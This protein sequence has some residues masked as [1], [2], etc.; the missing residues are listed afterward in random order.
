MGYPDD[1]LLCLLPKLI[2]Y[3]KIKKHSPFTVDHVDWFLFFSITDNPLMLLL[4]WCFFDWYPV[5][6]ILPTSPLI[7]SKC[8]VKIICLTRS[9]TFLTIHYALERLES[10]SSSI[11]LLLHCLHA[12]PKIEGKSLH[13]LF[14]DHYA[15][16][17]DSLFLITGPLPPL[18]VN[19]RSHLTKE[20]IKD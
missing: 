7:Q 19:P 15:I 4:W 11:L 13:Q 8:A 17:T 16:H 6:C 2:L 10:I 1:A 3:W 12:Y 5:V 14:L 18:D 9:L 20:K